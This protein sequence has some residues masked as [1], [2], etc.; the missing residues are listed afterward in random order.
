VNGPPD[1]RSAR[2]VRRVALLLALVTLVVYARAVTCGFVDYD[3]GPYVYDANNVVSDGLTWH[4]V[5]WAFSPETNHGGNWHP[6]TS[7]AHMLDVTVFGLA[8]AAGHHAVNVLL[9]VLDTVLLFAFLW[10]TTRGLWPAAFAA[11][12][13]ALHPLHV[14]SVAWVSERKDVLSTAFG[15]ATLI[16]Y[17]SW[18]ARGGIA[19][20][21]LA[22]GLFALGLMSKPMLVT[23]PFVLLLLDVW[24]LGRLPGASLARL[25]IEK[26]PFLALSVASSALTVYV[27]GSAG[28]VQSYQVTFPHRLANALISTVRYLGKTVWPDGF[29]CLYPHAYGLAGHPWP[30]WGLLLGG[31]LLCALTALAALRR[32]A[33]VGWLWYLGTL[34]PVIGIVQVGSQGMA[35]RYTYVPLI[36]VFF[37]LAWAGAEVVARLEA[38][39]HTLARRAAAVLAALVLAA[40]AARTFVQIG[41]WKSSRTLF[42]NAVRVEPSPITMSNLGNAY[43]EEG[44]VERAI[45]T[46]QAA[47]DLSPEH[48]PGPFNLGVV[49]LEEA[50]YEEAARAFQRT[51]ELDPNS[52]VAHRNLGIAWLKL[53]RNEDAVRELRIATTLLPDDHEAHYHLGCAWR[54]IG[55]PEAALQSFREALRLKPDHPLAHVDVGVLLEARG[56]LEAAEQEF[57]RALEI[58]PENAVAHH[59]LGVVL[60][61]RGQLEDAVAEFRQATVLA[62][63]YAKAHFNLG[64]TLIGLH[65]FDQA[66]E[67]FRAA[68]AADP[69]YL[70]AREQL[71][72]ALDAAGRTADAIA[73]LR[74]AR[75][76]GSTAAVARLA[77]LLA[78]APDPALLAPDEAVS[79]AEGEVARTDRGDATRLDVLAAAYAAADR[80]PEAVATAEEALASCVEPHCA[81]LRA[82]LELYRRG[83]RFVQGR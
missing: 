32:Y 80:F 11:A 40:L 28:A 48:A 27:Q 67:A 69:T 17:A 2:R 79:L 73:E 83:E 12:L 76:Q 72:F 59:D 74:E 55:K 53:G 7:L 63:D 18:T 77:W 70:A 31:L 24:P 56:E 21:A 30:W 47:I 5:A 71:A 38:G 15:L 35:D 16:A 65:R 64:S 41:V 75:S 8:S 81:A 9:H 44:D 62:P 37:A 66:V 29:T 34:V 78:V 25:A 36:G 39:G 23:W 10:R 58:D 68:L 61:E 45:R 43:R 1:D 82:R 6:L 19:R 60:R 51:I 14:E 46:Y 4:G 54:A 42:E 20:Y 33:L 22:L 50:R 26:L 3:D 57:R 13:F 52:P 49:L